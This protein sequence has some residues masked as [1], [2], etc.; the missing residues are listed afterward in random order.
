M[1]RNDVEWRDSF[2]DVLM[3]IFMMIGWAGGLVA[4]V[5]TAGHYL[6]DSNP[7]G[8]LALLF[9]PAVLYLSWTISSTLGIIAVVSVVMA[10]LGSFRLGGGR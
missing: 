9:P 10:L 8:W 6:V 4:W 7:A 2:F 3:G 1:E 5:V